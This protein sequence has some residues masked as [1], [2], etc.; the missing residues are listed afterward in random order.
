MLFWA[1]YSSWTY[2]STCNSLSSKILSYNFSSHP[3]NK[4]IK[5]CP[6]SDS[7]YIVPMHKN[8]PNCLLQLTEDDI[9]TLRPFDLFLEDHERAPHCYRIK[10]CTV[11]L[12]ISQQSIIDKIA[13]L[14]DA[15]LIT[16]DTSTYAHFVV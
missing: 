10:C 1:R 12:R 2:C 9:N 13:A 7:R 6:C 5:K 16:C 15:T 11:K 3:K 4:S 14:S 8:I